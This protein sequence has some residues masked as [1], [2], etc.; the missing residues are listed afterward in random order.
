MGSPLEGAPSDGSPRAIGDDGSRDPDLGLGP[1]ADAVS[2]LGAL[3]D[4][5]LE[6]HPDGYQRVHEVLHQALQDIPT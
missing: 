6:E 3:A 4:L 2:G 5:P 1:V